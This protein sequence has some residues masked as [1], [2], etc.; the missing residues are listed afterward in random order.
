MNI[1]PSSFDEFIG[2]DRAK[3]IVKA[4]LSYSLKTGEPIKHMLFNGYPGTGK[5]SLA[6]I[7][8][9]QFKNVNII[10]ELGNNITTSKDIW[11]NIFSKM[12]KQESNGSSI[13]D[14]LIGMFV[15]SK[16]S[17]SILSS[18]ED[19]SKLKPLNKKHIIILDEIDTIPKMVSKLFFRSL[20]DGIFIYK[21]DT[22]K[23]PDFTLIACCND[24]GLMHLALL[25]RFMDI[26][27]ERYS[28]EEIYEIAENTVKKIKINITKGAIEEI[29]KR[30]RL[31]PST[32]NSL[33][34]IIQSFQIRDGLN[35]I[36]KDKVIK[37]M[38]FLGIDYNGLKD[39]D[40]SILELL[41]K[42][43]N[44][45]LSSQSI[46]SIL[47]IDKKEFEL[48]ISPFLLQMGLIE[49]SPRGR[50]LTDKGKRY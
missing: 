11:D 41:N 29:S 22:I 7:L 21:G 15:P 46:C 30:S 10:E 26:K 40:R 12:F 43:K 48:I 25:R 9:N 28:P 42:S 19:N 49:I 47:G 34:Q 6:N 45:T 50:S 1:R 31:N 5:T 33:I 8:A 3:K 4:Q 32:C 39:E 20:E 35:T 23:L 27:F 16:I 18:F 2:N 17:K 14:F 37:Y 36:D 24:K 13:F 44:N 38:N